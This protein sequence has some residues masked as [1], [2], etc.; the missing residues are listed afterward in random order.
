MVWC[1][2][3]SILPSFSLLSPS[4]LLLSCC[5]HLFYFHGFSFL[6][7]FTIL[8]LSSDMKLEERESEREG[9]RER[10]DVKEGGREDREEGLSVTCRL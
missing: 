9:E 5:S 7:S 4:S 10:K 8:F 2:S 6:F 3:C 1:Q